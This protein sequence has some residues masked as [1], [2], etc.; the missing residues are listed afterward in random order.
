M[1]CALL[2][3]GKLLWRIYFMPDQKF[4][5]LADLIQQPEIFPYEIGYTFRG[6]VL[7]GSQLSEIEK[8]TA[9]EAL[10]M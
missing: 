2:Q 9:P 5:L 3:S 10:S 6:L 7:C 4:V 8:N 1:L